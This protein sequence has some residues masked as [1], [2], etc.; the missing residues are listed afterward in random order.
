MPGRPPDPQTLDCCLL[1][2]AG[3]KVNPA[4]FLVIKYAS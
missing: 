1:F 2:D 4:G 3:V